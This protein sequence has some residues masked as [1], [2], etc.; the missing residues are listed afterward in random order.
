MGRPAAEDALAGSLAEASVSAQ[1][2]DREWAALEG[3]TR[4]VTAL[5]YTVDGSYMLSG[6]LSWLPP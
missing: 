5:A 3:H 6:A 4:A 2:H 1:A